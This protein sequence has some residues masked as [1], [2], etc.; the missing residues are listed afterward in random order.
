MRT[1]YTIQVFRHGKLYDK[2]TAL[3]EEQLEK[4][5]ELIDREYFHIRHAVKLEILIDKK[6]V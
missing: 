3:G 6:E 4:I 5:E 2:Y 1:L